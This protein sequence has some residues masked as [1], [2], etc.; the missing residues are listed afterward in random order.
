[1]HIRTQTYVKKSK[2]RKASAAI[3]DSIF[4]ER[5]VQAGFLTLMTSQGMSK[6]S[7]V[8]VVRYERNICQSHS[9]IVSK[10]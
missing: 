7:L 4:K 3:R 5:N 6:A 10:K 9:I 2:W 8:N 1:M